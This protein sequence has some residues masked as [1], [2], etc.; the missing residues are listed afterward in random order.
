MLKS[1]E[2]IVFVVF[3]TA[4]LGLSLWI[5]ILLPIAI[6]GFSLLVG[7]L[8]CRYEARR[9]NGSILHMIASTLLNFVLF[10][11]I[12]RSALQFPTNFSDELFYRDILPFLKVS[13]Q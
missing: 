5:P 11:F 3:M 6:G 13:F 2:T 8:V 1:I 10:A 7:L 12:I 9:I 4:A